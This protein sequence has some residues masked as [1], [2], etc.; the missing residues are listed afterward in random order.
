MTKTTVVIHSLPTRI[1]IA[2]TRCLREAP[3]TTVVKITGMRAPLLTSTCCAGFQ[4]RF[5]LLQPSQVF[6]I[7]ALE[8]SHKN[9]GYCALN[10]S[11]TAVR[12]SLCAKNKGL[13]LCLCC[14]LALIK[15]EFRPRMKIASDTSPVLLGWWPTFYPLEGI[16]AS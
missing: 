1:A 13:I 8:A 3:S 9:N 2:E 11:I 5:H 6:Q 16:P 7:R 12:N 14:E 4:R 15:R 10:K